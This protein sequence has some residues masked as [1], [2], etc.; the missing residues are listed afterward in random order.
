[1]KFLAY[2]LTLLMV[3]SGV[4]SL[5]LKDIGFPFKRFV[6]E[7]VGIKY[8]DISNVTVKKENSKIYEFSFQGKSYRA[9]VFVYGAIYLER[10]GQNPLLLSFDIRDFRFGGR[11]SYF[12]ITPY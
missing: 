7:A 4:F 2:F 11:G 9:E 1:M 5:E 3:F 8:G 10:E 6:Y 12:T